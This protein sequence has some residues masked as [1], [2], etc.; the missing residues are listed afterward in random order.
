MI[1]RTISHYEILEQLGQGGMGIV[2][3]ARDTRLDRFVALKFLP[4]HLSADPTANAR[5]IQEAKAAS[6]LDHANICTVY[7]IGQTDDGRLFI[8]MPF[9]SG[10][11]LKYKLQHGPLSTQHAVRVAAQVA[12]GLAR[13]HEAGIVHRDIKPANIMVTER[14]EVKILDFGVAKLG[15]GVGMTATGSTIGTVAYMSPEQASGRETDARSDL[16]AVGVLLY[17]MLTG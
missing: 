1:G 13:A 16:W 12:H 4:P 10:E 3:K 5:F 14:D 7:E 8:S 2:Y 15:H 11:T 17:E 9:Y 6:A